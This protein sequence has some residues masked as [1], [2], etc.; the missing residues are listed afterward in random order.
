MRDY[1]TVEQLVV[2]SNLES[3]NSVLIRQGIAQSQR[4]RQL[5]DTAIAQMHSL[6]GLPSVR[7]LGTK[8]PEA[9]YTGKP[10]FPEILGTVSPK[11]RSLLQRGRI[12]PLIVF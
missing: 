7:R 1:A 3:V 9:K 4:L 12:R 5:N 2:L 6:L 8:E 10:D 11:L